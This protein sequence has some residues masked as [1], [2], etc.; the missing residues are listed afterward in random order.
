MMVDAKN[1]NKSFGTLK[2]VDNVSLSIASG[3]TLGIV[4]ESG[5]GKTTLAKILVG[6]TRADTGTISTQSKIQMVFQDPYTSLDPLFTVRALLEEAFYG[7]TISAAERHQQIQDMLAA[8]GLET[9]MLE[10]FPHEFSGGQRQR[11]AIARALL[12]Q[13]KVLVLDEVTSALDVLVQKQILDLLTRVKARFGLTY[14]FIS[15]NLRVVKHFADTIAVMKNGQIIEQQASPALFAH[16]Q[17]PYTRELLS[18]AFSYTTDK[19]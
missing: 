8:V 13:C 6:L 9:G 10:R 17:Q 7:K 5:C 3:H 12:T 1:L 15:H 2:A 11:I 18:A 16:P 14:I 19:P 4:G